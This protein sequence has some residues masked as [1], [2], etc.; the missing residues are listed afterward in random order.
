MTD[1]IDDS[2]P[3]FDSMSPEEMM[4]WQ[5]SMVGRRG[6][7][8]PT[9]EDQL[10]H[11]EENDAV[12]EGWHIVDWQLHLADER[13][14]L[15]SEIGKRDAQQQTTRFTL[16]E[17]LV[18]RLGLLESEY[19]PYSWDEKEWRTYLE[20]EEAEKAVR[21]V[22]SLLLGYPYKAER[23]ELGEFPEKDD[24]TPDFASMTPEE[25]MKWMEDFAIW[26]GLSKAKLAELS[27]E[28]L[29]KPPI[30][31]YVPY[32]WTEADLQAHLAAE[33]NELLQGI[34][35]W[36]SALRGDHEDSNK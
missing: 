18:K 23:I 25:T 36:L 20:K 15:L 11:L 33:Q 8:T 22:Q 6:I 28:Q 27:G 5:E 16:P 26:R 12:P 9:L 1:Q 32:G 10:S 4:C 21:W 24:G 30:T 34:V 19:V 35:S 17:A 13:A 3:D 29:T 14:R 31:D 2:L 7:P